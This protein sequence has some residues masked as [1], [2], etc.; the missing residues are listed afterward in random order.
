M[1]GERGWSIISANFLQP[2]LVIATHRQQFR[3][4]R[5]TSQLVA[6]SRDWRVAKSVFVADDESTALRYAKSASG[7]YGFYYQT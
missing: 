5:Q 7:P 4:G 3:E 1:V 6:S 2:Q